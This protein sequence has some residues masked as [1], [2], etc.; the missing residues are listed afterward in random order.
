MVN[1]SATAFDRPGIS[2]FEVL[3]SELAEFDTLVAA[4]RVRR[5]AELELEECQESLRK[6]KEAC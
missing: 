1:V 4:T 5:D 6:R 3:P 2:H